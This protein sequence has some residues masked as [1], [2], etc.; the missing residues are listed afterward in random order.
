LSEHPVYKRAVEEVAR[1]RGAQARHQQQTARA[2][3]KYREAAADY[4]RQ[5]V[6]ALRAGREA[7]ERPTPPEVDPALVQQLAQDTIQSS[8]ILRDAVRRLAPELLPLMEARALEVE[9]T[10]RQAADTMHALAR[11]ASELRVTAAAHRAAAELPQLVNEGVVDVAGLFDLVTRGDRLLAAESPSY[12]D[13]GSL[14]WDAPRGSHPF[15]T[16]RGRR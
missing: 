8:D 7:P 6:E 14:H 16:L 3:A 10:I 15:A 2:E 12:S 1:I 13:V 4:Q 9:E 11:E 5:A